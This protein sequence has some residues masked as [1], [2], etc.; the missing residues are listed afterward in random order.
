MLIGMADSKRGWL[1]FSLRTAFIVV[2]ASCVAL[3]FWVVPAERQRQTIAMVEARGGRVSY[4][5]TYPEQSFIMA[6]LRRWLPRA[7][8]DNVE[9]IKL[10]RSKVTDADLARLSVLNTLE[11]LAID[12]TQITD[13][14]LAHLHRLTKLERL[15]FSRTRATLDGRAGLQRVLPN[16]R[17]AGP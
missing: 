15:S 17:V 10:S 16:C 9:Q 14:G 12:D 7:Y 1:Q 8:F 2:T 5:G 13:A 4:A 6:Y 11:S 3:S